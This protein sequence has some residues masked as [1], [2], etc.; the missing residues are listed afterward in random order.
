MLNIF[1]VEK[2]FFTGGEVFATAN[3]SLFVL[4]N[5]TV[6]IKVVGLPVRLEEIDPSTALV[7]AVGLLE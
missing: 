2:S 7:I 3:N 1:S 5:P 6:V 4:Y